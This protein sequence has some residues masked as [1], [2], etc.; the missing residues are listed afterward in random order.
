MHSRQWEGLLDETGKLAIEASQ[1]L[2]LKLELVISGPRMASGREH[3][4]A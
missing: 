2:K 4:S 1:G 3:L